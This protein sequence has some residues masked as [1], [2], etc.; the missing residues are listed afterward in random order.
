MNEE[1]NN[2][3][4]DETCNGTCGNETDHDADKKLAEL[5][6][7]PMDVSVILVELTHMLYNSAIII[8]QLFNINDKELVNNS[9]LDDSNEL[10]CMADKY[11]LVLKDALN[12]CTPE[13]IIRRS[14]NQGPKLNYNELIKDEE[15]KNYIDELEKEIS[16]ELEIEIKEL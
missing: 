1:I 5:L 13:D 3:K 6:N 10:V 14:N 16:H 15:I 8:E 4:C 7:R 12:K 11:M 2:C 9:F